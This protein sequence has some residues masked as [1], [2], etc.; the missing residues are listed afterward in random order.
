MDSTME[1]E[2]T[3]ETI[4]DNDT[5]QKIE[6]LLAQITELKSENQK[7]S[8]EFGIQRGKMKDLFLQK[9]DELKKLHD[10]V[11]KLRDERDD[12]R[13]QATVIT[14][15]Y[16][17]RLEEEKARYESELSALNSLVN[18]TF[19]E[20]SRYDKEIR[21]L[22]TRN[23]ELESELK[24]AGSSGT[25]GGA[26]GLT[27]GAGGAESVLSAPG[28][29]L[30]TFA[31]KVYHQLGSVD[32]PHQGNSE[33]LEE[34]MRKAKEDAEVLRSLVVPLEEEISALK[35]KLR[36]TDDQLQKYKMKERRGLE[37]RF[38]SKSSEDLEGVSDVA[39]TPCEMC[40]NY[41]RELVETQSRVT[42]LEREISI[43]NRLKE[44]LKKESVFRKQ[45]EE[46]WSE[47][48][49]QHKQEVT[50]LQGKL[51]ANET[52]LNE[53][54]KTYI[55]AKEE[56]NKQF[57]RLT[58]E[59]RATHEKLERLQLEN[60]NL[61][62]KYN[63]HSQSLQNEEINL[64]NTVE[65]LQEMWLRQREDLIKARV[66]LEHSEETVKT[67]ECL[68]S[69]SE[70]KQAEIASR[71]V[72]MES[73]RRKLEHELAR[74]QSRIEQLERHEQERLKEIEEQKS[75]INMLKSEKRKLE[76]SENELR[77]RLISLQTGLE[78]GEAVQK[79]FVR[80]SQ[81][82]QKELERLRVQN[83]VLR[84][85][86]E[87]DVSECRGCEQPFKSTKG[88]MNCRHCGRIF[89][90]SCLSHKVYTG[91]SQRES[92]VCQVC[93]TLLDSETAPYFST[94]PPQQ[95]K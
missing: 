95:H 47:S 14:I 11:K 39:S 57:F 56:I 6:K 89:C 13:S 4:N 34:S 82:L 70:E 87:E 55:R 18:A 72:K 3:K 65:A 52:G 74:Y 67:L 32:L 20:A 40:L 78:N 26:A 77:S 84:W 86:H 46:K 49:E 51:E 94:G 7:S 90:N 42:E 69:A 83:N 79:D 59:R 12:A 64:P 37:E 92:R 91:R 58:E 1:K 33:N 48:K 41:E 19:E 81:S 63:R 62:G 10:E 80:L 30:S 16:E 53:L 9:E 28:A 54:K 29:M 50:E 73:E 17:S 25:G 8:E 75:L 45:M 23:A 61:V 38:S 76:D 24:L 66:G 43:M 27:G 60:E 35:N 71:L 68:C 36:E 44:E 93:H 22:K 5:Q 21:D 2:S 85:E 31:R 88:K 15:N